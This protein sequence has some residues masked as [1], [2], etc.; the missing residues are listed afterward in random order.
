MA[1]TYRAPATVFR[2][3]NLAAEGRDAQGF[4]AAGVDE[5]EVMWA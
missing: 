3:T 5:L 1:G 2:S 4:A